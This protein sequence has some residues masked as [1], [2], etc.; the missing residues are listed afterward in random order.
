MIDLSSIEYDNGLPVLMDAILIDRANEWTDNTGQRMV[1]FFASRFIPEVISSEPIENLYC[2]EFRASSDKLLPDLDKRFWIDAR[3]HGYGEDNAVLMSLHVHQ[4]SYDKQEIMESYDNL[5]MKTII[6]AVSTS[7]PNFKLDSSR[8]READTCPLPLP[9]RIM[10]PQ[11]EAE[12]GQET[13][14]ESDSEDD[15]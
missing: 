9:S 3:L 13:Q 14:D 11:P 5:V 2:L 8:V 10:E 15:G 1:Q 12:D 6:S 7:L 4:W